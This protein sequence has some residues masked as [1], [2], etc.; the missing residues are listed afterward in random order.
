MSMRLLRLA[1]H[2]ASRREAA[3]PSTPEPKTKI[4]NPNG[5]NPEALNL[6]PKPGKT[7]PQAS[8]ARGHK[9]METQNPKP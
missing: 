9:D 1:T 3:G 2:E 6:D 8:Q 7:E 5:L 4:A